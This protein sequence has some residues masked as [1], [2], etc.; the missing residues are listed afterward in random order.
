MRSDIQNEQA[1]YRSLVPTVIGYRL[2]VRYP[3]HL[4]RLLLGAMIPRDCALARALTSQLDKVVTL[5]LLP[6]FFA[7]TGMGTRIDLLY[8]PWQ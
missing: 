8:E 2:M 1:L 7:L 5:L 3:R 4:W 6:T